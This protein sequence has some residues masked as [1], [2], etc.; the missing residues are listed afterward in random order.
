MCEQSWFW[1]DEWQEKEREVDEHIR[2]GEII[3][4]DTFLILLAKNTE[5]I[6]SQGMTQ[7]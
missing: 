4:F 7:L 3:S 6:P 1:T 2:K 5:S